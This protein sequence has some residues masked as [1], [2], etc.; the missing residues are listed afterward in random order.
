M[1]SVNKHININKISGCSV[2]AIFG[3]LYIANRLEKGVEYYEKLLNHYSCNYNLKNLS[4]FIKE[5]VNNFIDDIT[6]FN[7]RLYIT[8]YHLENTYT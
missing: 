2:G 8:Y 5:F 7:N 1:Y 6:I 3:V 4:E